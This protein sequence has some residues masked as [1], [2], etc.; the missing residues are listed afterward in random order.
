MRKERPTL[1]YESQLDK[2]DYIRW[3]NRV[4]AAGTDGD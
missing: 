2:H 4:Y 1:I 3:N